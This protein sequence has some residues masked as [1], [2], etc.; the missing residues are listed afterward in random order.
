MSEA[1]P[2]ITEDIEI[3]V[4]TLREQTPVQS[5][6]DSCRRTTLLHVRQQCLQNLIEERRCHDDGAAG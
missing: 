4:F 2:Q 1:I 3:I 6:F 5:V